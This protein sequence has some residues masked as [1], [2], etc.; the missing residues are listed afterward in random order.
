MKIFVSETAGE[1][2]GDATLRKLR[3]D[4]LRCALKPDERLRLDRL[5][6]AYGVSVTTLREIL[7]R[8]V[9][10]GFVVAEGQRGFEVA[11]VYEADLRD[12]CELR[13]LLECHA[14]RRSI[15]LGSLDWEAH[16][17]SAHH[18][19]QSVE[20]KLMDGAPSSVEQ[21]VQFDWDFHHA[22]ISAC[23]MP[24]LMTTHSNVFDRYLRYH[25]L[26]LDFRGKPAADEHRRLRDLVIARD[27]EAAVTLLTSHVRA[28][29]EHIL[30][31]G[32]FS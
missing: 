28:G 5:R 24:A 2:V 9:V 29:M 10:E 21:W 18:K 1:S 19:L 14:L 6:E 11:P 27:A 20:A 12:I 22:T 3:F 8:L 4:I 16:V 23:D 31:T 13:L 26:A 30:A 25:L 15:E 7:N 32:K 17:V